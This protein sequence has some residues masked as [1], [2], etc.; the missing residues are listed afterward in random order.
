MTFQINDIK[1]NPEYAELVSTLTEEEYDSL[2]SSINENGL[3]LPIIINEH[4]IIL[5]GHHRFEACKQLGTKIK[6]LEKKFKNKSD[7]IIF[8]GECNL[9]RRQ[10]TP[11]QRIKIVE[12]LK[13][14]YEE[15]AK[16]N[17]SNA[18]KGL[19]ISAK[20]DTREILSK[21]A[22]VSHDTYGK[23]VTVLHCDDEDLINDTLSNEK[24][25]N[26]SYNK[27][28]NAGIQNGSET[29]AIPK[30][31]YN[32]CYV[33]PPWKFDNQNTGGS[34][35][36][37]ASQK[38]PTMSTDDIITLMQKMPFHKNSVLFMWATNAMLPDAMRIISELGFQYKGKVTW[39]KTKFL[40]LGYWY[41]NVTEDC[42]FAI[43]GDVKAFHSQLPNFFEAPNSKHSEKPDQMREII[44]DGIKGIHP[45]KKIE[46]FARKE[47]TSWKAWG[48]EIESSILEVITN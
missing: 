15:K 12:K 37:G 26:T 33:D 17:L 39:R 16:E 44:E 32:V 4:G 45:I 2:K 1:I 23:G 13:P 21:K 27:I 35:I 46:L 14:Y 34:L 24:K 47:T 29:P 43:K 11:L 18:G 48:N 7:E 10:L 28:R 5:D 22:N 9:Q 40:G 6:L 41:R 19:Q 20:V 36:S 25:I 3:Y 30:G 38:Y 42:L 8:V 31:L